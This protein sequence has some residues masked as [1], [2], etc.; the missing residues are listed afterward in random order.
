MKF[1]KSSAR[2]KL[3]SIFSSVVNGLKFKRISL[4]VLI[5]IVCTPATAGV[6]VV[7]H[8]S[9]IDSAII[10]AVV[11]KIFLGRM[12]TF[13]SGNPLVAVDQSDE[14]PSMQEFHRRVTKK[15]PATL[16]S[17]WIKVVTSGKG[18]KLK[19]LQ[20]DVAVKSWVASHPD[21]LGYI[22]ASLVDDSVKVVYTP[23]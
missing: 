2:C 17:Y 9:A 7:A 23:Q 15:T 12:N 11:K 22:D 1:V 16:H 10:G 6:V 14:Y 3:S 5:S 4:V 18:I 8:P 21:G 13:P 20:G 19:S